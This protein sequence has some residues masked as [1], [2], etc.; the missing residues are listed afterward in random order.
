MSIWNEPQPGKTGFGA[1]PM[2]NGQSMGA[3]VL[4]QGQRRHML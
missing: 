3:D 4:D 1:S 2:L